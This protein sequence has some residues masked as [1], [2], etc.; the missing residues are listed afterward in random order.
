MRPAHSISTTYL[1]APALTAAVLMMSGCG[2]AD[3]SPFE[4]F[5]RL[6]TVEQLVTVDFGEYVVPVPVEPGED[7]D[8]MAA[9]QVQI[10]FFLHAAVLPQHERSLRSNFQR[11]EGRFRDNVID[12]CRKTSVEDLLDPSLMALKTHLADSMKPFLGDARVER[13]HIVDPQVKR[14]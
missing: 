6:P 12:V 10:E 3:T 1:L 2:T 13:I 11:L 5:E 7:S 4:R 8:G 14:L 9:T